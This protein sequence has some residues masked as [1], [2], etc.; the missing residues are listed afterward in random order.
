MLRLIV[1]ATLDPVHLL[2][3]ILFDPIHLTHA[4]HAECTEEVII[5]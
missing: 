4:E 2:R 3:T 1:V 5:G